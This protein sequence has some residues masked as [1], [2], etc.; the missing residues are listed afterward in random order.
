MLVPLIPIAVFCSVGFLASVIK[1]V[2]NKKDKSLVVPQK[3][4][5]Q[6]TES[7]LIINNVGEIFF[8]LI[9]IN[10]F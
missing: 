3:T 4:E 7:S 2:G 9:F 8:E 6:R 10:L 5:A 1:I